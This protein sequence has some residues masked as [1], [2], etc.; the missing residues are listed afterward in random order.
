[1]INSNNLKI[2]GK[3]NDNQ[4]EISKHSYICKFPNRKYNYLSPIKSLDCNMN[5]AKS[6][7]NMLIS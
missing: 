3:P 2:G 1:M 5:C 6:I 7:G 4:R